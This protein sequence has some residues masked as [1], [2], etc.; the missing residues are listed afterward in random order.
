MGGIGGPHPNMQVI[1]AVFIFFT[2]WH[3]LAKFS[4]LECFKPRVDPAG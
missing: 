4:S 3:A 2:V 1:L